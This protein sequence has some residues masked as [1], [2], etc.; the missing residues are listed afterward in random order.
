MKNSGRNCCCSGSKQM[1]SIGLGLIINNSNFNLKNAIS[2]WCTGLLQ[3]W[4]CAGGSG[5]VL[6]QKEP[7]L[8]KVRHSG[9][10]GNASG[11]QESRA[12][13]VSGSLFGPTVHKIVTRGVA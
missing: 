4:L 1:G 13:A 11:A 10:A 2:L 9:R 8:P 6:S 7:W 12:G 5:N 3:E